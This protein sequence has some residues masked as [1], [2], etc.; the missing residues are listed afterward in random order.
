MAMEEGHE[1]SKL[2]PLNTDSPQSNFSPFNPVPSTPPTVKG[3]DGGQFIVTSPHLPLKLESNFNA[4]MTTPPT[5][6]THKRKCPGTPGSGPSSEVYRIVFDKGGKI[7]HNERVSGVP[8]NHVR[9]NE[10][11]GWCVA[12]SP[13]RDGP[14]SHHHSE[15]MKDMKEPKKFRKVPY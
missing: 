12:T 3:F 11:D 2:E 6:P 14:P 1:P 13:R 8:M 4:A 9:E 15:R 5:S 7:V 10:D